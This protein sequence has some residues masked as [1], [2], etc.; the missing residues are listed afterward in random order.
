MRG[1]ETGRAKITPEQRE[2]AEQRQRERVR[3]ANLVSRKPEIKK[4][5]CICGKPGN[6]LHNKEENPYFITF[7]CADCRKNEN[8]II[9]AE[10]YRFDLRTKLDKS[11][12]S[13]KTFAED[14]IKLLIN[15]FLTSILSMGEF[16]SIK[17][18]S[19]HQFNKV[20]DRYDKLDPNFSIRKR[21]KIHS[22]KMQEVKLRKIV[23]DKAMYAES[24]M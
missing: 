21:I 3:I 20:I 7:L 12:L 8:N 1:W 2:Q 24:A 16:C 5:C 13:A 22:N 19:R 14:D 9:E 23:E 15:E 17:G 18:I 6:I 11:Y 4:D 10:K